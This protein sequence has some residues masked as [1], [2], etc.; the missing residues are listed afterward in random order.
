MVVVEGGD[1]IG[2]DAPSRVSAAAKAA[3]S[4]T[5][6]SEEWT[7]RVIIRIGGLAERPAAA[8]AGRISVTPSA[9]RKRPMAARK[10][11]A[12]N[13]PSGTLA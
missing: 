4:P 3:V 7:V 8:P 11:A 9:S 6:S 2:A 12:V 10:S 1:H 5:A 13:A